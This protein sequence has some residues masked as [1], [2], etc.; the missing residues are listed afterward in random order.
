M[1][2]GGATAQVFVSNV[3]AG[4]VTRLDLR[5]DA[6]AGTLA[7][8]G[9]AQIASGYTHRCD[10]NALVV[11]PTGVALDAQSG[12]LFVASTGDNKI[13]AV[14][15]AMTAAAD[16]GRGAVL[17][18]D[19]THLHGPLALVRAP[20]GDLITSQGDAVNPD[21]AHPSEIVEYTASGGFVAHFS[22]DSAP[23]SAFGLAL[24]PSGNG[25]RF[26]AVDDGTN[27]L[28]IWIVQ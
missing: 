14:S 27:V 22:V 23:G 16:Q 7:V 19:P 25:F 6:S 13:Y 12:T 21:A 4:T 3:L 1:R 24:K 2:D 11:G 10:P 9:A 18:D 28:D 15:H 20:N 17:I 8:A 26:A 5:T